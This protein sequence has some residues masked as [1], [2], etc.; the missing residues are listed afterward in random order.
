MTTKFKDIFPSVIALLFFFAFFN[1]FS[2]AQPQPSLSPVLK[3]TGGNLGPTGSS[4]PIGD[5]AWILIALVLGYG[6]QTLRNRMIKH[7]GDE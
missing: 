2:F 7:H 1:E 4:A 5:G 3:G 6:V